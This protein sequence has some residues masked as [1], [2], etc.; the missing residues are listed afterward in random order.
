MTELLTAVGLVLALEGL[1][2]GVAPG[3]FK[4]MAAAIQD[5]PEE[6][7]RTAGIMALAAGTGL[8]WMAKSGFGS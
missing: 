8:V 1:A 5:M 6:R 3:A 7:L 2:Y 4:R